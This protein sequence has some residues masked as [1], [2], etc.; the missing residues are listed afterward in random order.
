MVIA[1][2][3]SEGAQ[4]FA[5]SRPRRAAISSVQTFVPRA[6]R[7]TADG[8]LD[9]GTLPGA[10]ESWAR[11]VSADGSVVAGWSTRD[12]VGIAFRWTRQAGMMALDTAKVREGW[13]ITLGAECL[14]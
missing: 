7:W 8:P 2:S 14:E 10:S 12:G 11:A 5:E 3:V 1:R 9:L 13:R 4:R 6:V